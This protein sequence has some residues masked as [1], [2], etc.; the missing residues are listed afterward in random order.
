MK[1]MDKYFLVVTPGLEN[2]ARDELLKM[3]TEGEIE[4]GGIGFSGGNEALYKANY[5]SRVA[6]K[7]LARIGMPF[8]ARDEKELAQKAWKLPWERWINVDLPV[9][10]SV[11]CSR[12]KLYHTGLVENVIKSVLKKKLLIEDQPSENDMER[13][14]KLLVRIH[15][16]LVT[17]S[18]DTSGEPLH[19]RGYRQ[20]V[21]K[22]PLRETIAAGL[23]YASG[24]DGATPL[25]DPFC[26]SGTIPIEAA[27]IAG[28]VPAGLNRSFAF[29]NMPEYDHA[30]FLALKQRFLK[31]DK[32]P[33]IFGYD[34]DAGAIKIAK[35]NATRA[36]VENVVTFKEQALSYLAN[37]A[38]SGFIITNPP[39]GERVSKGADLRDLYARLGNIMRKDLNGWALCVITNNTKHLGQLGFEM[40]SV[41]KVSNGGIKT[42]IVVGKA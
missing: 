34:R 40:G 13:I 14:T 2:I 18:I 5:L 9:R 37:P 19:K 33:E 20:E 32:I 25:I 17:V 1:S 24:W 7:V 28:G 31:T 21:T 36:G 10:I 26:G 39:Y 15:E 11:S 27:L 42:D 8:Y 6:S 23:I 35:S 29:Q 22:A 12:S 4:L 3:G 38:E 41:L 16:D 30:D